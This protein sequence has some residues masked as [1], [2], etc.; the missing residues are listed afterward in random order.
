MIPV[1][2][3]PIVGPIT[4]IVGPKLGLVCSTLDP[5]LEGD[6]RTEYCLIWVESDLCPLLAVTHWA[7]CLIFLT[8][9]VLTSKMGQQLRM[10][11][12]QCLQ[13]R[14]GAVNAVSYC[15]CKPVSLQTVTE[16]NT[17]HKDSCSCHHW[18]INYAIRETSVS[19]H[20]T[21]VSQ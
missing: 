1:S 5:A 3:T 12:T 6:R 21:T 11:P 20:P 15:F 17:F 16:M 7:S 18:Q 19:V 8:L 9:N 14:N 2:C 10:V 13:Q 4:R